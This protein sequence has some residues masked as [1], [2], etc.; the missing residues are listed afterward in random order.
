MTADNL[1]LNPPA[2]ARKLR[3]GN[4]TAKRVGMA[5]G[6]GFEPTEPHGSTVFKT[7]AI[8]HSA[9]PPRVLSQ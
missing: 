8:D 5:E 2:F 6:V 7:A 3:R 4:P 1:V 9:T